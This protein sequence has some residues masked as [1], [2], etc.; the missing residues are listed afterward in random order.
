MKTETKSVNFTATTN[1]CKLCA[2]LGASLVYRGIKR[3]NFV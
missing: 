1:A 2:P 3:N